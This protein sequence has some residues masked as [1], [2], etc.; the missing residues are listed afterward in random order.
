MKKINLEMNYQYPMTIV[1]SGNTFHQNIQ[2]C[3]YHKH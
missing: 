2:T 1:I 3:V